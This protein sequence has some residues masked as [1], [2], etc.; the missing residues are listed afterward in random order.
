[1]NFI[2][3]F[4]LNLQFFTAIPINMEIPM[5]KKQL[6]SSIQTIPLLGLFQ[7][8]V[9]SSLLY[10]LIHWTPF[11]YIAIAFLVWLLTIILTGGLHLD[12]WMDTWDA[13][14][15]YKDKEKRL[16]IMSDPHIGAFGVLSIIILLSAR[17][18]F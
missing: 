3:G 18:L 7:G 5:D 13:Y 11:S 14:F 17:F 16:K 9:Y 4:L 10:V 12:G 6:R 15:S 1:M 8:I 2:K